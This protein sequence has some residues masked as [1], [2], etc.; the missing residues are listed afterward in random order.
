MIRRQPKT[1]VKLRPDHTLTRK[2]IA[3]EALKVLYRLSQAGYTAYLVGGGVRDLLL[4]RNPKD[5]DVSTSARPRQIQRLFRNAYLIGRRFRLVH[6]KFGDV[7]I[8]TSTFRR[9]PDPEASTDGDSLYHHSDNT[10]GTPE[11]DALRRDFTVNALFYDIKTFDVIDHVGGLKDLDKGIIRCIGVPDVRFQEDPVRMLR[12][13]RFAARME[14]SIERK[15]LKAISKNHDHISVAPAPRLLEELYRLFPYQSGARAFK[16]L[17]DTKLLGDLLPHTEAYLKQT[18]STL[19]WDLMQALDESGDAGGAPQSPTLIFA[20]LVYAP[21]RERVESESAAHGRVDDMHI[22]R[23]LMDQ[24]AERFS[25]HRRIFYDTLQALTAQKRFDPSRRGGSKARLV[26]H[27]CF[28]DILAMREITLNAT[29]GDLAELEEWKTLFSEAE[30]RA[31]RATNERQRRSRG[32]RRPR[33]T[34]SKP[35]E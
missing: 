30:P 3:P 5:F 24:I 6:V 27:P 33:R 32:R 16:L 20:V 22:A 31:P 34:P 26:A 35:K 17:Y 12:A 21:F 15:T 7:V 13:V 25:P 28:P 29:G 11:E 2:D 10:Y 23:E 1:I 18:R 19:F 9:Q 4:G 8:E 14:F